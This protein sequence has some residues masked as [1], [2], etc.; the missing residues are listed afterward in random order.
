MQTH[1]VNMYDTKCKPVL[2]EHTFIDR[3]RV[4]HLIKAYV[5]RYSLHHS[6]LKKVNFHKKIVMK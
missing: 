3:S 6:H 2:I 5:H 1:C 4:T